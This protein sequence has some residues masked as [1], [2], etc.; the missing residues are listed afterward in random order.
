MH[1]RGPRLQ[2]WSHGNTS[3]DEQIRVSRG[4]RPGLESGLSLV[5]G[6]E[7]APSRHDRIWPSYC[8]TWPANSIW[9]QLFNPGHQSPAALQHLTRARGR[10]LMKQKMLRISRPDRLPMQSNRSTFNSTVLT[11][12]TRLELLLDQL[13][14]NSR[15][16]IWLSKT[17]TM[18]PVFT[19]QARTKPLRMQLVMTSANYTPLTSEW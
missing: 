15:D 4:T 13:R 3:Q 19:R 7:N 5:A 17:C 12:K 6:T 14:G 16:G 11:S 10:H 9:T 18:L 2:S 1:A 8:R